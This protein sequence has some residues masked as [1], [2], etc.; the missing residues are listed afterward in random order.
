[1]IIL[2]II[3]IIIAISIPTFYFYT[4]KQDQPIQ[5]LDLKT[6][7]I[8]DNI[9]PGE[10]IEFN[11]ELINLGKIKTYNVFLKH[12][13]IG[14]GFQKQE[15]I[16]VETS[17]LKTSYIQLPKEITPQRYT[18][19]TTATYDNKKAFSTFKFNIIKTE[20]PKQECRENWECGEFQPEECPSSEIQTRT[21]N[22]LNNCGTTIYKPE[23][24]KSCNYQIQEQPTPI[25]PKEFSGMTIW[26]KLDFIKETAKNNPTKAEDYCNN[27]EIEAH[28]DECYYNIAEATLSTQRCNNI[29]SE[30][31]QDRCISN[32][33]K[34]S[35]K[36]KLCE[37]ITKQSRKDSCYM[38]FVN[39]GDYTICNKI[40]NEHLREVCNSLRDLT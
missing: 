28:R 26:E 16:K 39:N 8:K 31:T 40:D 20:T 4:S 29:V 3:G 17:T 9:K 2:A 32:I 37:G 10:R 25:Q 19:K 23:T 13:I 6:N 35:K 36:S 24:E 7:L 34:L 12:E 22:D 27:L 1:M 5:P 33:A 14:T 11:I 15:T 30:R 21:C 18:L 38:N